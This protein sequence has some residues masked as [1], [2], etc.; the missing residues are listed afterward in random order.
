[1]CK[2][3]ESAYYNIFSNNLYTAHTP[4]TTTQTQHSTKHS[5]P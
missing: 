3:D 1:M 4:L 2:N 5:F